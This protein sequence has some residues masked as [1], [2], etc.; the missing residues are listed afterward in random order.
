MQNVVNIAKHFML[1]NV[2]EAFMNVDFCYYETKEK[3][4]KHK[5]RQQQG[6]IQSM[7]CLLGPSIVDA[8][9]C[10]KDYMPET[11]SLAIRSP[12]HHF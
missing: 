8:D 9:A 10:E 11:W 3:R 6:D 2:T 12:F 7:C 5:E 4:R 1:G